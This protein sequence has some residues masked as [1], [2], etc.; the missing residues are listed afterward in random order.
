M[1]RLYINKAS[2]PTGSYLW[3]NKIKNLKKSMDLTENIYQQEFDV[4]I[5]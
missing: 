3:K 2:W 4:I 5:P 1:L